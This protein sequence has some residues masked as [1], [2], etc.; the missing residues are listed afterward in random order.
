MICAWLLLVIGDPVVFGPRVMALGLGLM[1]QA[2]R[3][4]G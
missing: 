3:W 1:H 2:R 4:C